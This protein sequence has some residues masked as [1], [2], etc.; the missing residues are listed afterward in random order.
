MRAS[1][2]ASL[3]V[4]AAILVGACGTPGPSPTT[5]PAVTAPLPLS[6]TSVKYAL[7]DRFR[8][9]FFCDPD[10]Y[11]IG[12]PGQ[13][14]ERAEDLFPTIRQNVEEFQAITARL[15]LQALTNF[16]SEQKLQVYREHKRLTA[17]QLEQVAAGYRFV[18][19]TGENQG[20]SV[21]GTVSSRG[22]IAVTKQEPVFN[23]C[24]ICL[25]GDSLVATPAGDVPAKDIAVGMTVWTLDSNGQRLSALVLQTVR[26]DLPRGSLGLHLRLDDGRELRASAA[27]PT[28]NGRLL[29]SYQVGEL[30]DGA[31]ISAIDLLSFPENATFDL[32]P[33]GPT[34][35]YWVNGIALKSTLAP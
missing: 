26:R 24:P 10:F 31:R 15:R 17:I 25:S 20:S 1:L 32:L 13:E 3:L 11:P 4:A 27:H 8:D 16:S 33:A 5:T 2:F 19:R 35:I 18:L 9:I 23:T 22:T 6:P 30:L 12:R 14:E 7:M 21:Q 34:A 29:G 28:A